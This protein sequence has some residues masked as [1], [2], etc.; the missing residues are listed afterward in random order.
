MELECTFF[1][2]KILLITLLPIAFIVLSKK[3]R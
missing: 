3:S 2:I 1:S